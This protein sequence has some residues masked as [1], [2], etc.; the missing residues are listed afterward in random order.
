M[1]RDTK[2]VRREMQGYLGEQHSRSKGSV[3]KGPEARACLVFEEHS[4]GWW[5]GEREGRRSDVRLGLQPGLGSFRAFQAVER[6]ISILKVV[7]SP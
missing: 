6:E 2:E 4:P 5:D 3:Y 1:S 7:G